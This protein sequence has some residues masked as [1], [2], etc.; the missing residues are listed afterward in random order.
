MTNATTP[1][2]SFDLI[3]T[4]TIDSLGVEVAEYKHRKTGA[5]HIHLA[6]EKKENVFLV[7]LPTMPKESSGVAH[8]LEHTVLCGSEK[9]PVRDPFFMMMRRSLSTFMNAFTSSDWTAYPFATE[10]KKDFQNLLSVYIDAVFFSRL[11]PLDF[12]Q[13]GHRLEFSEGENPESPLE[14]KGVVYNEM[15]GAMSSPVSQLYQRLK[16]HLF[17]TTTYHFNSGGEP[18]V[19]PSLSYDALMAF[20]KQHYHPTNALFCTFGDIPAAEH[21]KNFEDQCLNRFE[22]GMHVS[23]PVEVRRFAPASIAEAYAASDSEDEKQ[24]HFVLGWHIEEPNDI[25]DELGMDLLNTQL[26]GS[27]ASPLRKAIETAGFGSPSPLT[28]YMGVGRESM[29]GAGFQGCSADD[30]EAMQALILKTLEDIAEQGFEQDDIDAGLF[31][32]ELHQKQITG[33]RQPYGLELAL[34]AMSAHFYKRPVTDALDIGPGIELLKERLKDPQYLPNLLRKNIINNQHRVD[35]LLYPDA[36]LTQK[37]EAHEKATMAALKAKLSEDEKQELVKQ[38]KALSERQ[39]AEDDPNILPKLELTDIPKDMTFVSPS[40]KSNPALKNKRAV[41]AFDTKT[42]GISYLQVTT[43]LPKLSQE[44]LL[45]INLMHSFWT[46]VGAQDKDYLHMQQAQFGQTGY[47]TAGINVRSG[48]DDTNELSAFSI[49][50]ANTLD[51]RFDQMNEL[52]HQQFMSPRFDEISRIKE[53]YLLKRQRFLQSITQ[54]G[55][56][57]AMNAANACFHSYGSLEMSLSGLEFIKRLNADKIDDDSFFEAKAQAYSKL[58]QKIITQPQH[59][60]LVGDDAELDA[61]IQKL[62]SKWNE[63]VSTDTRLATVDLSQQQHQAWLTSTQIN[64]CAMSIP[65]VDRH[66]PDT[67]AL[68]LLATIMNNE[69]LHTALRE[70]GGAYGGGAR[71]N[72]HCKTF[73]FYSYR[74]PRLGQTF[75]DFERAMEWV[76][77][78]SF[79]KK[80]LEEATLSL[81]SDIDK[82]GSPSGEAFN[83]FYNLL[84]GRSLEER[85]QHRQAILDVTLEDLERVSRTYFKDVQGIKA[86]VTNKSKYETEKLEGFEIHTI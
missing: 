86:A 15:K 51:A 83:E 48:A 57:Y 7:G 12:A 76:S 17:S 22:E 36:E 58:H 68:N 70:K 69:F 59:F 75:N 5:R 44:E 33:S 73:D 64:F 16:R 65:A 72:S 42:N 56:S 47:L 45:D 26:T 1:Y 6:S 79:N 77:N 63:P 35:L 39:A 10:N 52:L 54:S 74:D 71:A 29:F 31:Q 8:I 32:L 20:Y 28:G 9:Y 66:H 19:I 46:E 14:I 67:A 21:Q 60:C 37:Q 50:R 4:S 78:A 25:A 11:D 84:H 62:E 40:K 41:T 24:C 27:S 85:I 43:K 38:A 80:Q 55:H 2:T 61:W 18:D 30:K 23:A 34:D 3:K 49:M 81:M 53:L 82:P 13:E